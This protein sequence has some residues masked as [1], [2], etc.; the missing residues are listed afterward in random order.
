MSFISCKAAKA[1]NARTVK[2]LNINLSTLTGSERVHTR[3]CEIEI[4]TV[5][6][7]R[8]ALTLVE[9]P[10]LSGP[11]AQLDS[12]ILGELFRDFDSSVFSR[13]MGQVD[14]L[15]GADYFG[16][17]PK[18]EIATDGANL[19]LMEGELGVCVQVTHSR[20]VESTRARS[21]LTVSF[22]TQSFLM[23]EDL[24]TWFSRYDSS[25]GSRGSSPAKSHTSER[26]GSPARS[27]SSKCPEG[28]RRSASPAGSVRSSS[29]VGSHRS[30]SPPGSPSGSHRSGS[31]VESNK[32]GSPPGSPSGSHAGSHRS[33]SPTGS[34][35]SIS[36]AGSQRS[37]SPPPG[38]QVAP[39]AL[40]APATP[41]ESRLLSHTTLYG[42]F[43]I[44]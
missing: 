25:V 33:G 18:R 22:F 9:L 38:S 28:S 3:L 34:Q 31:P 27:D 16:L 30:G 10:E 29:P 5:S 14:L 37:G 4:K 32:S 12:K 1:L 41:Q 6:G 24:G 43:L 44:P 21:G 42:P 13:P 35:R 36:P 20:L 17:H 39:P 40:I 19:S 11:V 7:K 8:V 15:L 23:C 2:P 26:S